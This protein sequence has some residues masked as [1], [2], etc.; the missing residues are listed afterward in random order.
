[1]VH[2]RDTYTN[3]DHFILFIL[4]IS[5]FSLS[6]LLGFPKETAARTKWMSRQIRQC[7]SDRHIRRMGLER[8]N[9]MLKSWTGEGAATQGTLMVCKPSAAESRQHGILERP[10][11]EGCTT[12]RPEVRLGACSGQRHS[13]SPHDGL[14]SYAR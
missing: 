2:K 12:G 1:M 14:L 9:M 13:L 10:S 6:R 5:I 8:D 3:N 4:F 11:S 7:L